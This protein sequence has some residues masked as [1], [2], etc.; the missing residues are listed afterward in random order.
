MA[1]LSEENSTMKSLSI[2][3]GHDLLQSEMSW[4][5]LPRCKC[6]APPEYVV[7]GGDKRQRATESNQ[8]EVEDDD[9]DSLLKLFNLD[10]PITLVDTHNH[11][12]QCGEEFRDF[13][14]VLPRCNI[15]LAATVVLAVSD[16]EW[17]QLLMF[18]G[19][20]LDNK[21]SSSSSSSSSSIVPLPVRV[22]GLGVHPW[23]VQD[24]QEGWDTKLEEELI[25]HPSVI[26]GEIGLCKCAR[27]LRGPEGK[28]VYWPMQMYVCNMMI[29]SS[30]S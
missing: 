28:T 22:V 27:N 30:S 20:N 3:Q 15:H 12:L 5:R 2:K 10:T 21:S 26:M 8:S 13:F 17:S 29:H 14:N 6:C 23:Y 16:K 19:H 4:T 7:A 25:R 11:I 1:S 18:G 9:S 24:V